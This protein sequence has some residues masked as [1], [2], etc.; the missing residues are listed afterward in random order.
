ML[1]QHE[2]TPVHCLPLNYAN[3]P[4]PSCAKAVR[5][6]ALSVEATLIEADAAAVEIRRTH[7]QEVQAEAIEESSATLKQNFKDYIDRSLD[8]LRTAQSRL[9]GKLISPQIQRQLPAGTDPAV[10][11]ASAAAVVARFSEMNEGARRD[12]VL[13]AY[14]EGDVAT[15]APL[16]QMAASV[17]LI[18][19]ETIAEGRELFAEVV[20]P[21]QYDLLEQT[22]ATIGIIEGNAAQVHRELGG[23]APLPGQIQFAS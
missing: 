17:R 21:A 18:D 23:L 15:L 8:S 9:E 19:D 6:S 13:R 3:I 4:D 7:R 20:D 16:E 1:H 22:R 10:A 12:A 2:A 5:D 14:R 11:A